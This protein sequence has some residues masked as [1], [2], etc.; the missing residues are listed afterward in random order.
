MLQRT[1]RFSGFYNGAFHENP[2][3]RKNRKLVLAL[4]CAA[5]VAGFIALLSR[6]KEPSYHGRSLSKWLITYYERDRPSDDDDRRKAL[7]AAAAI[8]AIGTHAVPLLLDWTR[9]ETTP[10]HRTVA[11]ALPAR[12]GNSRLA[13]ATVFRGFHR[14]EAAQQGFRLLGT[15][16]ASAI[17]ELRT[18]M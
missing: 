4:A 12:F 9:Y 13:R 11:R 8:R 10:W 3:V 17:P 6:G 5:I 1:G 16:A 15:N 7:L 18:M 14:A 2:L